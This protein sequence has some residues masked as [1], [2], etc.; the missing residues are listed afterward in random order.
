[1][2]SSQIHVSVFDL[3]QQSGASSEFNRQNLVSEV[4]DSLSTTVETAVHQNKTVECGSSISIAA[5]IRNRIDLFLHC[6]DK[7]RSA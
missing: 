6:I 1:M 4:R 5:E 2:P 7:R 3:L